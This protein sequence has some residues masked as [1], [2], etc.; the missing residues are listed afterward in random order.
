[1]ADTV[2]IGIRLTGVG[3]IGAKRTSAEVTCTTKTGAKRTRAEAI[4]HSPASQEIKTLTGCGLS[5]NQLTIAILWGH[6]RER[7]LA[8]RGHRERR[9]N[10]TSAQSARDAK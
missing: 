1:M 7:Y 9:K 8:G 5:S 6:M 3:V 4:G 2:K 10:N